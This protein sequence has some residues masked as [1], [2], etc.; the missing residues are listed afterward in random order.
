MMN[1]QQWDESVMY[2][3]SWPELTMVYPV[4]R[5]VDT[6]R[7]CALLGHRPRTAAYVVEQLDMPREQVAAVLDELLDAGHVVLDKA[8]QPAPQRRAEGRIESRR[9][10]TSGLRFLSKLWGKL[11]S[12]GG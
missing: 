9:E 6:A 10:S 12:F 11:R 7:I 3:R 2:L 4:S 8:L 1:T 5:I